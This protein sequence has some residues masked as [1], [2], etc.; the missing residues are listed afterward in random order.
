MS[1]FRCRESREGSEGDTRQRNASFSYSSILPRFRTWNRHPGGSYD[2]EGGGGGVGG[3]GGGGSE[4]VPSPALEEML[5]LL[6][7]LVLSVQ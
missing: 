6:L 5:L 1:S 3:R 4:D 2:E 7:F